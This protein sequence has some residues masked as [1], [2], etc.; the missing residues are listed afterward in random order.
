MSNRFPHVDPRIALEEK[1]Q[2][3]LEAHEAIQILQ[4]KVRR[5]EHLLHLKDMRIEDLVKRLQL[6]S[7][8]PPT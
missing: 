2:Q 4:V 1:E 3:L 6:A 8:P 7:L 5:M